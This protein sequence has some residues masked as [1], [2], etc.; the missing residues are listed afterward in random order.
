M[1]VRSVAQA[2]EAPSAT[3]Q[4][5]PV[6]CLSL[7]SVHVAQERHRQLLAPF[8]PFPLAPRHPPSLVHERS[9]KLIRCGS[10]KAGGSWGGGEREGLLCG[11]QRPGEQVPGAGTPG[12]GTQGPTWQGIGEACE[13]NTECQSGCC[14]T[15]SLNPQKFCTS[16]TIFLQCLSWQKVRARGRR[17]G[18]AGARRAEERPPPG[19]VLGDRRV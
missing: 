6:L 2:L 9:R 17:A 11:R 14:V 10:L 18:E 19:K 8:S 5:S 12:A 4:L 16:Q 1:C 13:E 3:H 7:P 15:N